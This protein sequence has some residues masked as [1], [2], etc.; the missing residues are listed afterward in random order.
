VRLVGIML[1]VY[2]RESLCS[3]IYDVSDKTVATGLLGMMVS[4]I[5]SSWVTCGALLGSK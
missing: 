3:H 4:F 1:V 5:Q 2:I